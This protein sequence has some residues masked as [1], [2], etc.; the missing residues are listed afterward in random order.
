MSDPA[1]AGKAPSG[2]G[3]WAIQRGGN[4]DQD[5]TTTTAEKSAIHSKGRE[6]MN[7]EILDQIKPVILA[8]ASSFI[9]R[10]YVDRRGGFDFDAEILEPE[11]NI[12]GFACCIAGSIVAY[13]DGVNLLHAYD[14]DPTEI[15]DRAA[16]IL[17]LP[18]FPGDGLRVGL[19][20]FDR[21]TPGLR[22]RY[23][24]AQTDLG[25]AQV[26]CEAIDLF[27]EDPELFV[28]DEDDEDSWDDEEEDSIC[29][30][31]RGVA[32]CASAAGADYC[33]DRDEYEEAHEPDTFAAFCRATGR[34]VDDED[35]GDEDDDDDEDED[36]DDDDEDDD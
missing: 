33:A 24:M 27:K 6:A 9:L 31:G 29:D 7:T 25:R 21:W 11:K 18:G 22:D 4:R 2:A 17:G 32:G 14:H 3:L 28:D 8:N 12:C 1:R 26:A 30:C 16:A 19:F 36:G 20:H 15:G 35:E 5:S 13:V 23:M 10:S 34:P